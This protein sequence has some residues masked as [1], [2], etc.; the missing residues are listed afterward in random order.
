M[1]DVGTPAPAGS[2]RAGRSDRDWLIDELRAAGGESIS[3]LI[4]YGSQL[5][6]ASPDL[7]S[8]WDFVVIV[9]DYASFHRSLVDAGHHIRKPWLLN[10]L[11][12][13]LPPSITAFSPAPDGLPVAKCAIV[14]VDDFRRALGPDSPDHFLKGRLVQ[15]VEVAWA[16]S[17]E[18]AMEIEEILAS[19]R[20]RI[21]EWTAPWLTR[22]ITAESLPREML[23]ISYGGEIRPEAADR[24]GEVFQSQQ[25]WLTRSYSEVLEGGV[26]RGELIRNGDGYDFAEAP[27]AS[28]GRRIR[29][30]FARSKRRATARWAKHIVTFNDWLTYIQRKAERRTGLEL[31]LSPLE[32]RFPLLFLWPKLFRVLRARN[33]QFRDGDSGESAA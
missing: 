9:R 7:H 29:R 2:G 28:E 22:P 1:T 10:R 26:E 18:A 11:A 33:H 27:A 4:I 23:A 25:G 31:P 30:Y 13:I 32:R 16:R 14:S 5:L 3:A 20:E 17:P 19:A 12:T 24:V 8:A 6:K 21:F 15:Q